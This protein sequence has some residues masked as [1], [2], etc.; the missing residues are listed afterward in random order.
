MNASRLL[1]VDD[2]AVIGRFVASVGAVCGYEVRSVF[3]ADDFLQEVE[4]WGPSHIAIHLRTPD[5]DGLALLQRLAARRCTARMVVF[6]ATEERVIDSLQRLGLTSGL[7]IA[8]VLRKPIRAKA[9]QGVLSDIKGGSVTLGENSLAAAIAQRDL[10]LVFQPKVLLGDSTDPEAAWRTVGFEALLRWYHPVRGLLTAGEF[11]PQ[12]QSTKLLDRITDLVID[13]ALA[14]L[15]RWA[16]HGVHTTLS[17]NLS[18][19]CLFS[20]DLVERL[21]QRC[22]ETRV[23]PENLTLELPENAALNNPIVALDALS[24]L[25]VQGF[26]LSIDGFRSGYSALMQLGR[27]PFSEIKLDHALVADCSHSKQARAIVLR[28]VEAAHELGLSVVAEG[29]ETEAGLGA[30]EELGCDVAQGFQIA[31]PLD[32]EQSLSWLCR[33]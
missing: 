3:R 33:A 18:P 17:I 7:D 31:R 28:T 19:S 4:S 11:L 1:I 12:I 25:R 16:D 24:R 14:Q 32:P 27:M 20:G 10:R 15:R 22:A 26:H 2:D 30:A 5:T 23:L 13:G 29:V 9:L 6:T 8:A 21:S